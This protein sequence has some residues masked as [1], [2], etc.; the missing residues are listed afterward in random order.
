MTDTKSSPAAGLHN[1]KSL[2]KFQ[3]LEE[4]PD[5]LVPN[6][7]LQSTSYFFLIGGNAGRYHRKNSCRPVKSHY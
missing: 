1:T 5:W 6:Y 7:P 4:I 2:G 3:T